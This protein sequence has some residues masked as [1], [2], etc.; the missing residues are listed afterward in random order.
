MVNIRSLWVNIGSLGA[1][2]V[3]NFALTLAMLPYLTRTL[4]VTGWGTVVFVQLVIN[5]LVWAANWGFYLGALKNI[6]AERGDKKKLSR[7]FITTWVA[8]W[9]ITGGMF[10]LLLISVI[11]LP[12]LT[13]KWDLYIAA[14]GLLVGNT[15]MPLWFLNGLE[16]IRESALIQIIVKLVALPWIFIKVKQADDMST[17]LWINSTSSVFV[18]FGVII[19][20]YRA[21]LI[22]WIIPRF[23]DILTV[24]VKESNLFFSSMLANMNSALVPTLL[25]I[26]GDGTELGYFN[27]ADRARSATITILHPITHALFPRMCYLISSGSVT[28][29]RTL[30]FAGGG[31]FLLSLL[32]SGLLF[33]FSNEIISTLG[34]TN[35]QAGSV[36]L[37]L[38]A[39]SPVLN[40][41]SSFLIHQVLIP[42][43]AIRGFILAT[44]STLLLNILLVYPAVLKYGANGGAAVILITEVYAFIFLA[45]YVFNKKL[46]SNFIK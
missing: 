16:K 8:Q 31:I 30:Y 19:W 42:L 24:I 44:L 3:F 21:N 39:F 7:I 34:G 11:T 12:L 22:S 1:L 26:T 20:I 9:C 41:A 46:L 25:G 45:L 13:D 17:Y 18:G 28:F 23:I 5:Y 38:L 4:G 2:Q 40:T 14:S 36:V 15:L 6:S 10:I 35:Y 33:L 37:Q 29:M 43:G 27:I 32:M